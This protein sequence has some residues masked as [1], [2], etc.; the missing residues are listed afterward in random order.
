M[1][2][3]RE[4][5]AAAKEMERL[6][7]YHRIAQEYARE[8]DRQKCCSILRENKSESGVP[9]SDARHAAL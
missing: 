2:G 9:S 1:M 5:R 3:M 6:P 8:L 7:E 4:S